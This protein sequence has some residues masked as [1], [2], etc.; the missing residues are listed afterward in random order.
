[1][2]LHEIA[3]RAPRTRDLL[4]V[5]PRVPSHRRGGDVTL[6]VTAF[7]TGMLLGAGLAL[8]FAPTSGRKARRRIADRFQ[9]EE[10]RRIDA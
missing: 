10:G 1:M 6:L 7:G 3:D 4:D 5:L 9:G 8:L 2:T